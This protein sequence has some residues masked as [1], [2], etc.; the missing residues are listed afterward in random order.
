VSQVIVKSPCVGVCSTGIGD[1]VC[2]GCKR[3][4]HEIIGWNSYSGGE[5][6]AILKRLDSL[7]VQVVK[8]KIIITNENYLRSQ[9]EHQCIRFDPG[10][11]PYC[12]VFGLL[13]AGAGQISNL[14]EFGCK[15][16]PEYS[17]YRLTELRDSIDEDF[18]V[19]STVHYQRYFQQQPH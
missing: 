14:K 8:S 13:K 12:W 15:V 4:C 6:Q 10:A 2:R 3:Y 18:Y 11:N 16:L 7:L 5:R 17:K 9:I 1:A 19:L